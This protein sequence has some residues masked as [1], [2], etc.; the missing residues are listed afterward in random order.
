[1]FL[2]VASVLWQTALSWPSVI[3]AVVVRLVLGLHLSHFLHLRRA[4]LAHPVV[5]RGRAVRHAALVAIAPA[6]VEVNRVEVG[7]GWSL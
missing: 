2:T 6:D 1:M 4:Q 7:D 5:L 3:I